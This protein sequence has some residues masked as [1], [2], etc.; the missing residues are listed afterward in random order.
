MSLVIIDESRKS[1]V[2]IL[3]ELLNQ[4][5]L[6]LIGSGYTANVYKYNDLAI[7]VLNAEAEDFDEEELCRMT[8]KEAEVMYRL[9]NSQYT[10]ELVAFDEMNFIIVMQFIDGMILNDVDDNTILKNFNDHYK[11]F[12][13]EC[14]LADIYP[15]DLNERNIIVR[16]GKFVFIDFGYYSVG[17]IDE[18]DDW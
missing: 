4:G 11:I 2:L 16:D 18:E 6:P 14:V 8:L 5:K 7:K 1:D 10:P 15:E 12:K 13:E 9:Q 3:L 17:G